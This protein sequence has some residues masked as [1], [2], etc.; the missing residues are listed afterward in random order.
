MSNEYGPPK[1]TDIGNVITHPKV[2]AAIYGIYVI[3][4]VILGGISAAYSV[5][6]MSPE[7]LSVANSVMLY[8]GVPVGT[9]AVVHTDTRKDSL[10]MK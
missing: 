5:M 4:V 6:D 8:L 3:A 2:R 10:T 9:L 1:A 7:W